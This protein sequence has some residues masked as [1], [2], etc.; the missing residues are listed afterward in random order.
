MY[1]LD[2][3]YELGRRSKSLLKRKEFITREFPVVAIEEGIG[4]WAGAAKRMTLRNDDG[5][6]FGAGI[7]GSYSEGVKLLAETVGPNATATVRY[8]MLSPDGVPRF[9]VVIDYHPN[10]RKD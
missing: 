1:R 8:F 5:T 3:A 9:P 10:G 4:N 6:T 7:R 2:T